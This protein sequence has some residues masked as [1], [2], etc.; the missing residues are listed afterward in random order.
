MLRIS[1]EVGHLLFVVTVVVFVIII[2]LLI[3]PRP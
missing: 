2:I 3:M 1:A